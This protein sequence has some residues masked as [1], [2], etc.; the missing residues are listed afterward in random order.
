VGL[1]PPEC[2]EDFP[3][4]LLKLPGKQFGNRWRDIN[5]NNRSQLRI[6]LDAAALC[7]ITAFICGFNAR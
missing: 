4:N 5:L 7:V 2:R 3:V 6:G 1:I